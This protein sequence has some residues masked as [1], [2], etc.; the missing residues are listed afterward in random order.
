[1]PGVGQLACIRNGGIPS[2]LACNK[3]A[4]NPWVW[5]KPVG[6]PRQQHEVK[7]I[8]PSAELPMSAVGFEIFH[9]GP[10]SIRDFFVLNG[11]T[12]VQSSQAGPFDRHEMHKDVSPTVLRPNESVSF[13]RIEPLHRAA[14]H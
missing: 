1:M 4:K 14:R 3:P 12:L 10:S 9:R 5:A 7:G 2:R 11:L 6:A 8:A 13:F